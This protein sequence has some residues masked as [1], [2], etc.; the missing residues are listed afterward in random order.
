MRDRCRGRPDCRHSPLTLVEAR[1]DPGD[2]PHRHPSGRSRISPGR[3][4]EM[5]FMRP[6][7]ARQGARRAG[8]RRS[9]FGSRHR[10]RRVGRRRFGHRIRSFGPIRDD[11][12]IQAFSAGI[13]GAAWRTPHPH[14]PRIARN[15]RRTG[16]PAWPPSRRIP[17]CSP[18]SRA[19]RGWRCRRPAPP[20]APSKPKLGSL[21]NSAFVQA[22]V[23]RRVEQRAGRLDRHALCRRRACRRS[24]RC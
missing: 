7:G 6:V 1:D 20:P 4:G 8:P 10:R 12:A 22:A 9:M 17:P 16:R 18:R 3:R 23:E 24:S 13:F 21:R 11:R 2:V 15:S 19:D 14:G 5:R